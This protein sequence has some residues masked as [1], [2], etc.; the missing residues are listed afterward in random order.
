MATEQVNC[1]FCSIINRKLPSSI[2]YEDEDIIAFMDINPVN[3]GHTL[4]VPKIHEQYM[5]DIP[6]ET[7]QKIFPLAQR[8]NKNLRRLSEASDSGIKLEAVNLFLADGIAAGQEVYHSHLHVIPRFKG[9]SFKLH[10]QYGTPPSRQELDATA[11]RIKQLLQEPSTPQ[12]I[13]SQTSP[14]IVPDVIIHN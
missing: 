4:V 14:K 6:D 5:C 8:I 11:N 9:D 12:P 1:V 10:N 7:S 13:Q 2:V 3:K